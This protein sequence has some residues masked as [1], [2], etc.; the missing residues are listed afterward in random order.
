MAEGIEQAPAEL[1][2]GLGHK[3]GPLPVWAWIGGG[4][5]VAAGVYY[6][7]SNR[8]ASN[9]LAV[10]GVPMPSTGADL[11][12]LGGAGGGG[13]TVV[14]PVPTPTPGYLTNSDWLTAA[15]KSV[16]TSL[17]GLPIA[18]IQQYLQEFLSGTSPVG[19]TQ[20]AGSYNSVIQSALTA[21]G[22]P[23][24]TPQLNTVNSNPFA[25]NTT[26]LNA[27]L[28]Y[29]PSGTNGSIM[30][31]LIA[32]VNGT[33][34]TISQQAADALLSAEQV[35]GLGPQALNY[36]IGTGGTG[37]PPPTPTSY[38]NIT[39]GWYDAI[40]AAITS[41]KTSGTYQNTLDNWTKI[42]TGETGLPS[43]LGNY[44]YNQGTQWISLTKQLPTLSQYQ[45]WEQQWATST[46][47][48]VKQ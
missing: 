18:Q 1:G 48:T 24:Q 4:V 13:G 38:T 35:V 19:S 25:N 7:V 3:L 21:L 10:G 16:S 32:L 12:G 8:A 46:G 33:S 29:L 22:N 41:A 31:E 39:Q 6:F 43:A 28:E 15:I 20:A 11:S 17:P 44:I 36:T 14:P 23:P 5:V 47:A 40:Q 26:W 37:A 42:F 30:N 34:T 27:I 9:P 45:M 2:K